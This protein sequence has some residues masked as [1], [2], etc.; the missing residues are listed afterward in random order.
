VAVNRAFQRFYDNTFDVAKY[1]I[2][3][4]VRK[5]LVLLAVGLIASASGVIAQS[6]GIILVPSG[7][8]GITPLNLDGNGFSSASTNGFTTN[9]ISQSEIVYKII[10]PFIT[11]PTGDLLRGPATKYSDIVK[12]VDSSG[13]YVFCDGT[14]MLFR[15]RIGDIVSGSKGYSALID[16]D[17]KFGAT[18][19]NADT[20]Y[21]ARTTGSNGNPGFE[22]EVVLES[23][24]QVAIYYVEGWDGVGPK[25]AI[26]TY[27]INTNSQVSVALS[28][29]SGNADFF[30]DFY[31]PLAG[32]DGA[33]P[34]AATTPLRMVATTVMAPQG[35]VGGPKSDIYGLT[36]ADY[37]KGWETEIGGLPSF[38]PNDVKSAGTGVG[39]SCSARPAINSPLLAGA[40]IVVSGT[41]TR[42]D[43]SKADSAKIYIYKNAVLVD[44]TGKT[45]TGTAWSKTL[46]LATL[47]ANDIVYAKAKAGSESMCEQSA[48]VIVSSCSTIPTSLTD[49]CHSLRGFKG[50]GYTTGNT[51]TLYTATASTTNNG[52]TAFS[53]TYPVSYTGASTWYYDGPNVNSSDPCTG[54][55]TDVTAGAYA[56]TQSVVGVTC[57]SEPLFICNGLSNTSAAPVFSDT[58]YNGTS[59]VKGKSA[60]NAIVRLYRNG[61][62]RGITTA[63]ASGNFLFTGLGLATGDIVH[64]YAQETGYCVSTVASK[65]VKCYTSVPVITTGSLGTLMA[66]STTIAGTSSEYGGTVY[67]YEGGIR[68]ANATVSGTG[69]WSVT[70]TVVAS[71]SYT[72]KQLS[73]GCTDTSAASTA[74]LGAGTTSTCPV[75]GASSY[76]SSSA[77]VSGTI[78]TFTGTIRVYQ[79]S[80]L[81][82]STSITSATVWSIPANT[83][84]TNK[85]FPGQTIYATAQSSGAFESMGCPSTAT[86]TCTIP[87]TPT[88]NTTTQ[89]ISTGGTASYTITNADVSRYYTIVDATNNSTDYGVS[90][91]ASSA[92]LGLTTRIFSSPGTYSI[93]LQ[94]LS[95]EGS[96]CN[97]ISSSASIV[98]TGNPLPLTLIEFSG[99]HNSQGAE[100]SWATSNE[101]LVDHFV[102]E[103]SSDGGSYLPIGTLAASGSGQANHTYKYL[104]ASPLDRAYYRLSIIDKDGSSK[105][106][107]AIVLSRTA[108]LMQTASIAPNP[109]GNEIKVSVML[110]REGSIDIR[111]T[112]IT[113]RLVT[114]V[115]YTGTAGLNNL[116]VSRLSSLQ[117]G[118]Y[119]IEV[120]SNNTVVG[121]QRMEKH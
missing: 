91:K 15:I 97:C 8:N 39:A 66:G 52:F 32:F 74:S 111:I 27:G 50:G 90:Q 120:L 93:K 80:V 94:G 83:L 38:T 64:L 96:A 73:T 7:G 11:E 57:P 9:D 30:Y 99:I 59:V 18:G 2:I 55:A 31:V 25:T 82:G 40:N 67:L 76:N 22:Y 103:R 108:A 46:T 72:A 81:I 102:V 12:N 101:R 84:Y 79:D 14:N 23:N 98:V 43:V 51:V 53:G 92:S 87:T 10:K 112:D 75:F 1:Q 100:L 121:V 85:I 86:T 60:A 62:S 68:V 49:T 19:P 26:H 106:S 48:N 16:A 117:S 29:T 69:T 104:D 78:P 88:F 21:K 45:G 13:F 110:D 113:G 4:V 105:Y 63:D 56:V 24:F 54:G 77:T 109:F 3:I 114:K 5:F 116:Q 61:V 36:D 17:S 44:S 107:N 34:I 6:P 28:K 95:S 58:L 35:A 42:A 37:M 89:N 71:T 119:L 33:I 20:N 115:S 118:L 70:R 47:A 41:W 65:T